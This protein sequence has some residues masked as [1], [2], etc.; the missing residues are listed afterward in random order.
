[1]CSF[2]DRRVAVAL[3]L[4]VSAF[5]QNVLVVASGKSE[6][7]KRR[8]IYICRRHHLNT[9]IHFNVVTFIE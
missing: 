8:C 9:Q 7:R 1:M 6:V 3:F 5:G 2:A 4:D